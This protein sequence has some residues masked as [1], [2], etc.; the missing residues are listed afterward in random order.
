MSD[1][2]PLAGEPRCG[3]GMFGRDLVELRFDGA[4]L[5]FGG[6]A[7]SFRKPETMDWRCGVD[8]LFDVARP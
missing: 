5:V 6:M 2:R 7:I 8:S 3:C 4:G 1:R